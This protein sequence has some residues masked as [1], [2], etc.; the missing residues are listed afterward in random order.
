MNTT[1][2]I[3]AVLG[4]LFIAAGLVRLASSGKM[5]PQ[6]KAWLI[7]GIAFSLVAAWLWLYQP[8]LH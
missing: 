6:A 1:H 8:G 2:I 4:T 7:V 3:I 5:V